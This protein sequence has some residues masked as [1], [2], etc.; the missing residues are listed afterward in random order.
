[1]WLYTYPPPS[2]QLKSLVAL[3]DSLSFIFLAHEKP[4][5]QVQTALRSTTKWE[6][7]Q[8]ETGGLLMLDAET[9]EQNTSEIS[10][11]SFRRMKSDFGIN[12]EK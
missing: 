12:S 7:T 1:M 4:K 2:L 10:K 11:L 8:T 9:S 5:R 3:I 6:P